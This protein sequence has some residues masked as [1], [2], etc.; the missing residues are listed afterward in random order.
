MVPMSGVSVRASFSGV[1]SE[2]LDVLQSTCNNRLRIKEKHATVQR[3]CHNMQEKAT[4]LH[5]A[6]QDACKPGS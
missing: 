2:R 5:H 6:L 4:L 1:V 3:P